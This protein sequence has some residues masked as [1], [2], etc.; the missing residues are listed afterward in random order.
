[1]GLLCL[2]DYLSILKFQNN[3]QTTKK[4]KKRKKNATFFKGLIY[5][6]L[7]KYR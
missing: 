2:N 1:M 5:I 3:N 7:K 4:Y 6:L